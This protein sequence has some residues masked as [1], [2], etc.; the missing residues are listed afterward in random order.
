MWHSLLMNISRCSKLVNFIRAFD[1]LSHSVVPAKIAKA[2]SESG[3]RGSSPV[4]CVRL[5][6]LSF[7]QEYRELTHTLPCLEF[8]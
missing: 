6:S 7:P 4:S 1:N 2:M 8:P 3:F 5:C